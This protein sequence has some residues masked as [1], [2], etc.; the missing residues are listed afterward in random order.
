MQVYTGVCQGGPLDGRTG[1]SRFPRG[2]ILVDKPAGQVWIYDL[3]PAPQVPPL[4]FQ[5]RAG[6][7]VPLDRERHLRA[8]DG[9]DYDVVA[10]PWVGQ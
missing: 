4:V 9:Q 6:Y 2:F 10:A 8:A 3:Q 1:Q 5:A 7:P